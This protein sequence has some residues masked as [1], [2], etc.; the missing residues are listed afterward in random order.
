MFIMP[1]G[2]A[3][4]CSSVSGKIAARRISRVAKWQSGYAAACKAVDLGSIPGLA[5]T[6]SVLT[7]PAEL[8][9]FKRCLYDH[10]VDLRLDM[11]VIQVLRQILCTARNFPVFPGGTGYWQVRILR[12][13]QRRPIPAP[14]RQHIS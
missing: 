6:I 10:L 2:L 5:S 12:P 13:T 14:L 8:R 4:H 11:L 7:N 9:Q 3:W 1:T